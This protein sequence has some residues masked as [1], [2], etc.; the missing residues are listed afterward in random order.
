VGA[1][2]SATRVPQ[3][4]TAQLGRQRR[5][6]GIP[7]RRTEVAVDVNAGV[8]AGCSG[9]AQLDRPHTTSLMIDFWKSGLLSSTAGVSHPSART[10]RR[11]VDEMHAGRVKRGVLTFD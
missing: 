11:V 7:A 3:R 5:D 6:A 1:K 10:F 8:V 9:A 4:R 2:P